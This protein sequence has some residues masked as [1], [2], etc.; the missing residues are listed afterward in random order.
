M[1]DLSGNTD[2]LSI[3]PFQPHFPRSIQILVS[4]QEPPQCNSP[5]PNLLNLPPPLFVSMADIFLRADSYIEQTM[6][7]VK[8]VVLS[9]EGEASVL[10]FILPLVDPALLST[11]VC[12][13]WLRVIQ[14]ARMTATDIMEDQRAIL[15]HLILAFRGFSQ[16]PEYKDEYWIFE[17]F[18]N[19]DILPLE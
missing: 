19:V 10:T 11:A 14:S 7:N 15:L 4:T 1:P 12:D 17:L 3:P 8:Q 9:V 5:H 18:D 13:G 6:H 2:M 16:H